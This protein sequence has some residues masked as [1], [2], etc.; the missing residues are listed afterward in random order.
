[1]QSFASNKIHP[2]PTRR[3]PKAR[4]AGPALPAQAKSGKKRPSAS[5]RQR[6]I[7]KFQAFSDALA[8]KGGPA[9]HTAICYVLAGLQC[10]GHAN[11]R[12]GRATLPI[13]HAKLCVEHNTSL[14]QPAQAKSEKS[15]PGASRAGQKREKPAPR[16]RATERNMQMPNPFWTH[17]LKKVAQ[18]Q[19]PLFAMF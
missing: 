8:Q 19:T 16:Q 3:R 13:R 17:L 6:E 1:M 7:R 9:P 11:L 10:I 14:P 12:I 15:R 18:H 2:S 4:K 5:G